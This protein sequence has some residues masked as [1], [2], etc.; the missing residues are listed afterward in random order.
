MLKNISKSFLLIAFALCLCCVVYP[1]VLWGFGRL[2]FPFQASGSVLYGLNGKPVGSAL[3]AQPF[4]HDEYFHPRPSAASYNGAASSSAALA[5]S[6]Y[7][8][9][10]RVVAMLG[11]IVKYK[12]GPRAGQLVSPDIELWIK[13]KNL[14][15]PASVYFDKWR[16]N[17]PDVSLEDVPGDIVTTSA[18]GL[19]PHITLE[20]AEFQLDR[21]AAKWAEITHHDPTRVRAEIQQVLDADEFAPLKGLVGEKMVNVLKVNLELQKRFKGVL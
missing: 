16:Q 14:K 11:S 7:A 12:N 13:N 9:R 15:G 21:V 5:A 2:F 20:N 6:N 18:S 19:D 10:A 17:N 4:T 1:A 8:L 3:I